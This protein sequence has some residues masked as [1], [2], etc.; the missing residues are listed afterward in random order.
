MPEP[1][2]EDIDEDHTWG[3]GGEWESGFAVAVDSDNYGAVPDF[4]MDVEDGGLYGETTVPVIPNA[5]GDTGMIRTESSIRTAYGA[6]PTPAGARVALPPAAAGAQYGAAPEESAEWKM[7]SQ[8]QTMASEEAEMLRQREAALKLELD[9]TAE[10]Q[11]RAAETAE[12]ERQARLDAEAEINALKE[13]MAALLSQTK[14]LNEKAK[15]RE[16]EKTERAEKLAKAEEAV[17]AAAD[18]DARKQ[19]EADAAALREEEEQ[20]VKEAAE[21]EA[22]LAEAAEQ[23]ARAEKLASLMAQKAKEIEEREAKAKAEAEEKARALEAARKKAEDEAAAKK[24]K[25]A[26]L[27]GGRIKCLSCGKTVYAKEKVATAKHIFHRACFK[28]KVCK[29]PL[30]QQ[31]YY[32]NKTDYYCAAHYRQARSMFSGKNADTSDIRASASDLN[33]ARTTGSRLSRAPGTTIPEGEEGASTSAADGEAT[34]AVDGT[35]RADSTT[36]GPEGGEG[37]EEAAP[38]AKVDVNSMTADQRANLELQQQRKAATRKLKIGG[39]GDKCLSCAKTVYAQ[40]KVATSKHIFHKACF[41]C[42]ECG[43]QLNA[44]N[45][46]NF[47]HRYY[48]L[49]HHK[50]VQDVFGKMDVRGDEIDPNV[51]LAELAANRGIGGEDANAAPTDEAPSGDTKSAFDLAAQLDRDGGG[52][53]PLPEGGDSLRRALSSKR[54]KKRKEQE[55]KERRERE[56]EEER[57]RMAAVRKAAIP[58]LAGS[59]HEKCLICKKTVYAQERVATAKHVFHKTCFRCAECGQRLNLQNNANFGENYYCKPHFKQL[60]SLHGRMDVGEDAAAIS[61]KISVDQLNVRRS[62]SLAAPPAEATAAASGLPSTAEDTTSVKGGSLA[63]PSDSLGKKSSS[64]R[65]KSTRKK[66]S[67]A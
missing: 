39:G 55:D 16:G 9:R 51:K 6:M 24:A 49:A 45:H 22:A 4:D 2:A 26:K 58:K 67:K 8:L 60:Q 41:K 7:M 65:I 57:I 59:G 14:Q 43:S 29:Q 11:K 20:R 12:R 47:D 3:E 15:E 27:G 64:K 66:S 23:A 19:A 46:G 31:K 61:T 32:N 56:A 40:E 38:E 21:A 28:C 18:E 36:P 44:K 35:D 33:Q 37:Q 42:L 62:V 53:I 30:T 34:S 25:L 54:R 52:F 48:C 1:I 17:Q 63:P 50:Q 5:Y 13:Q 10:E